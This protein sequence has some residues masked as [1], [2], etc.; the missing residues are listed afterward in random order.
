MRPTPETSR[1]VLVS[2]MRAERC[3][4]NRSPEC[5]AG[6]PHHEIEQW[7]LPPQGRTGV[8]Y[9]C[10]FRSGLPPDVL[11]PARG[12]FGI[13]DRGLDRAVAQVG[14]QGAGVG[15]FVRQRVAGRMSQHVRVDLERQTSLDPG[16]LD[17]L[18]QARDAER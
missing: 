10:A 3:C 8:A 13:S 16:P 4:Q 14:L 2:H 11:E 15:S 12:E 5:Y 6:D 1:P 17:Q 9:W 18:L 7:M